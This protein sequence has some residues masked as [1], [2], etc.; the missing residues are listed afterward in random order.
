[1]AW[2]VWSAGGGSGH[3]DHGEI[4]SGV[5]I[6][7]DHLGHV[8]G[9]CIPRDGATVVSHYRHVATWW[10]MVTAV[11]RCMPGMPSFP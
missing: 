7:N 8:L 6:P 10:L 2:I 3:P 9:V 1:M 5:I 4:V 11:P